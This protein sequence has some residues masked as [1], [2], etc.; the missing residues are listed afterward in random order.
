M[1][2]NETYDIVIVGAGPAGCTAALTLKDSGLNVLMLE[3]AIFPRD[4]ACGDSVSWIVKK[5][6]NEINPDFAEELNILEPKTYINKARLYSPKNDNID[7]SFSKIG[8]CI[9]RIDL[10]NWLFETACK[11]SL[12]SVRQNVSVKNVEYIDLGVKLT[13]SN[14]ETIYSKLI[15]GCDGANS[16]I[17]RKLTNNKLERKHHSGAVSQYIKNVKDL[18]SSRLEVYFVKGFSPGYFWIFPLSATEANVGFGMLSETI[19]V[20][21]IDLKKCF[22]QIISSSPGIKERFENAEINGEIRGFGLP[23]GSKKRKISG[24][25]FML[26][27]DAA[28]LIDPFTGE[29][30]ERAMQSG[31]MAAELA[32]KCFNENNF[33]DN[34]LKQYDEIVYKKVWKTFKEH[35]WLQQIL[36]GREWLV[37]LFIKFANIPFIKK[38][39][40][41]MFY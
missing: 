41:K 38:Q 26:C 36:G 40:P 16:I 4:K 15:I 11:N 23:L 1:F 14:G 31:K 39:I 19:S 2:P 3:K 13:T 5:V 32:I 28:S 17:N 29:G 35:Y 24:N 33:S 22:Y 25:N 21:N 8:Y 10:D 20:Q 37:N 34:F 7:V 30:I 6:L 27:G 9:K 18:D 12:L